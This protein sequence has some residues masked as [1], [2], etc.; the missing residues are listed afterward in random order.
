M[1]LGEPKSSSWGFMSRQAA[2]Y[3]PGSSGMEGEAHPREQRDAPSPTRNVGTP[4]QPFGGRR[5]RF[6]VEK[7][8]HWVRVRVRVLA[9]HA[10]WEGASVGPAVRAGC[11]E[12][13]VGQEQPVLPVLPHA[14]PGAGKS[15]ELQLRL[16]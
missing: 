8:L 9:T 14:G 7:C 11:G 12:V 1:T 3:S 13:P 6:G 5:A 15:P 16:G 10:E 2:G 4:K